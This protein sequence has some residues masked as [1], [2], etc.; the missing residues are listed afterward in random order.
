[1]PFSPSGRGAGKPPVQQDLFVGFFISG[2]PWGEPVLHLYHIKRDADTFG[3]E[4][5][6]LEIIERVHGVNKVDPGW[7]NSVEVKNGSDHP[8]EI[9][10]FPFDL[11]CFFR[12][13]SIQ[14]DCDL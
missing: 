8:I 12:V 4:R 10:G 5:Y 13:E 9:V 11:A 2:F 1:M 14:R 6:R 7:Q 3:K